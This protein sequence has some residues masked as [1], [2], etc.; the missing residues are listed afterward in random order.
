MFCPKCKSEY[1]EGYTTC[2]DCGTKLVEELSNEAEFEYIEFTT[3]AET[4]NWGLIA[5]AKSILD[6]EGIKYYINDMPSH[7]AAGI[8]AQVQVEIS[9][10]EHAKELLKD[11]GL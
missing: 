8:F 5:L 7:I 10:A 2:A 4:N 3:I 1:S 11:I 6:S 9:N